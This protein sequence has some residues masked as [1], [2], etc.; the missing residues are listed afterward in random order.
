[1]VAS[2]QMA[3]ASSSAREAAERFGIGLVAAGTI[4]NDVEAYQAP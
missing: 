3:N 4:L 2:A 1:M